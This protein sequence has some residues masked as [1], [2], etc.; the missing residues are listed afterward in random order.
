MK[1]TGLGKVSG[2]C[3]TRI[4]DCGPRAQERDEGMHINA[5][6]CDVNFPFVKTKIGKR[7]GGGGLI[8]TPRINPSPLPITAWFYTRVDI[9]N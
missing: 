3:H 1:G 5:N 8:R 7:N 4:Q 9:E 6:T 2:A